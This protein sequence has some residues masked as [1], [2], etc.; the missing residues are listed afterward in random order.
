MIFRKMLMLLIVA[1]LSAP[2]ALLAEDDFGDDFGGDGKKADSSDE[3]KKS[4]SLDEGK[5][6]KGKKDD[7]FDDEKSAKDNEK[8]DKKA[9]DDAMK[10][11]L[12]GGDEE[13]TK[14]IEE[15][16]VEPKKTSK[17]ES[18]EDILG[19]TKKKKEEKP[20]EQAKLKP[21]VLAKGGYYMLANTK[22]LEGTKINT[23]GYRFGA[24]DEG[25]LGAEYKGSSIIAKATLNL[26]TENPLTRQEMVFNPLIAMNYMGNK[27]GTF[28]GYLPY[29]VVGGIKLFDM[30]IVK[31]GKMIPEYGIMDEY[32]NI[33]LAV[34]TPYGT[35]SLQAV[36]GIVPETDAGFALGFNYSID[37][38]SSVRAGFMMGTGNIGISNYIFTDKVMGIYFRAGYYSKMIKAFA[39]FQYR[40]DFAKVG[41]T[42]LPKTLPIIGGGIAAALDLYGFETKFSFDYSILSQLQFAA[43]KYVS[44]SQGNMLLHL[45][46]GYNINIDYSMIDKL[47]IALRFD[48]VSGS[49]LLTSA[50]DGNFLGC[51]YLNYD[52]Y[53]SAIY[54]RIGTGINL[55]AKEFEG[56]SSY[57]G[58]TFMIQP[59]STVAK[60]STTV[61]ATVNNYGF[62][63][64][65]LQAGAQ[66]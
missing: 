46:P 66:F 22:K 2:V 65:M 35:R 28:A 43:N 51:E 10:D 58:L 57:A 55:F 20:K 64:L 32:Q 18:V 17:K 7:L 59:E 9:S 30:I 52:K 45:M 13:E 21:I 11:L 47:Q 56:V 42:A 16:K 44:K 29:E 34:G 12:G 63:T 26:R 39:S 31:A 4:D 1:L 15:P 50:T 36:E 62:M 53:K 54:F 49:Y 40:S 48:L 14:K 5:A 33:G 19:T 61:P 38:D 37:S 27:A 6:D 23:L 24:V 41:A 25:L 60:K 8:A 3:G